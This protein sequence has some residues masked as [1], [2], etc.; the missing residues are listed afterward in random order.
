MEV[1]ERVKG[2]EKRDGPHERTTGLE[3]P[4]DRRCGDEGIAQVF[5]NGDRSNDLELLI[6]KR[7][8]MPVADVV[9]E[10]A[11]EH[12]EGRNIITL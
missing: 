1:R 6:R 4:I 3:H 8:I 12:I 9:R 7:Q 10:I 2:L 5:E 11:G